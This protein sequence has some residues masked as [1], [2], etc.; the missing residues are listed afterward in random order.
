M[1]GYPRKRRGNRARSPLLKAEKWGS[2]FGEEVFGLPARKIE[3]TQWEY[4]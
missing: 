2:V 1:K 3:E 4:L